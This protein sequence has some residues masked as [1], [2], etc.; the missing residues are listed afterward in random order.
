MGPPLLLVAAVVSTSAASGLALR[1]PNQWL[2]YAR[3]PHPLPLKQALV[4]LARSTTGGA[5]ATPAYRAEADVFWVEEA[6]G[7]ASGEAI[8]VSK[9]TTQRASDVSL[10]CNFI[11][12]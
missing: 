5:M 4:E 7:E 6:S 2:R 9:I 3:S 8:R 11:H 12:I 1:G 10:K